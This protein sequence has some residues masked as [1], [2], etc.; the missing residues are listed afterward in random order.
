[1]DVSIS[2]VSSSY[3]IESC[4]VRRSRTAAAAASRGGPC[5]VHRCGGEVGGRSPPSCRLSVFRL[6]YVVSD[7]DADRGFASAL[8][9]SHGTGPTRGGGIVWSGKMEGELTK[10]APEGGRGTSSSVWLISSSYSVRRRPICTISR[11]P[12]RNRSC[13]AVSKASSQS[14]S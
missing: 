6:G 10:L 11:S 7:H 5:G 2:A 12:N 9:L 8:M 1:M 14:L 4:A 13:F 3:D